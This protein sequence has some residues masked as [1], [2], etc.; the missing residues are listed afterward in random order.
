MSK[1]P[2]TVELAAALG[3]VQARIQS[4]CARAGR[5]PASVELLPVTK[6]V[7]VDRLRE[8]L[9]LG[10]TTLGENRVQEAEAKAAALP[11][12]RW[13]LIGHL[14]SNKAARA[15]ALFDVI[16]S[17]DSVELAQRLDRFAADGGRRL[18][19]Y[20]E[21]NVDAD[22]AKAGF[23]PHSLAR[24]L[25]ELAGLENLELRGLMTV[26]RLAETAERARPTFQRLAQLSRRLRAEHPE[27]AP[28]LSMG[29]SA[30]FEAAIEEGATVVRVGSA[31]FG[32]R[33]P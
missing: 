16:H 18:P 5:D 31:I 33:T 22:P 28:G 7:P 19:V 12:A 14:Q 9:A 15:A 17:V 13:Q 20:L 26:G 11:Q 8:A 24:A 4:A 23:D 3:E 2:G 10:L 1:Q 32:P 25:P 6:A 27:L 21:V 29:M 30:D